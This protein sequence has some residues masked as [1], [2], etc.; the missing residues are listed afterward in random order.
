MSVKQQTVYLISL[1]CAKN[2]VDSEH[3]L[4]T[5]ATEGY[6]FTTDPK[7]AHIII[8]NTCAFITAAQEETIDTILEL[9]ELKKSGKCQH[10]VVTGCLAQRYAQDIA[11]QMPEVD[12]VLGTGRLG[13]LPE[14]LR[15]LNSGNTIVCLG[16]P[17]GLLEGQRLLSTPPGMAYLK[18]AEG[19]HHHC[20]YCIIPQLRGPL[21]SRPENSIVEE[22]RA[23][24]DQGVRELVLIA[25]D[26]A[27]YGLDLYG[28]RRLPHLLRKL[29]AIDNLQ[30]IRL[31]YLYPEHIN[32][33]LLAVM[34]EETKICHYLDMP[35]Q[36]ISDRILRAMGRSS[37]QETLL[38]LLT[39]VRRTLPDAALRTTF[40]VGFPGET[41][42][43]FLELLHFVQ[44]QKFDWVGAFAYSPQHGTPANNLPNQVP[45]KLK[46]ERLHEL[47]RCQ[48]PISR[49]RNRAWLGKKLPV[50]IE[51][52]S[53]Q[54]AI[55]RCFRQAP[56]VDGITY[57]RGEGLLPGQ[58]QQVVIE[59]TTTYDLKGRIVSEPT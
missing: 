20:T 18:L 59:Q 46:K 38:K 45:D 12:A 2:L 34:T 8:V 27:S 6:E 23:L 17:G 16:A 9:A 41:E 44:E 15:Q 19:C 48:R 57:V 1:G 54:G 14:V 13:D 31:L 39:Q 52:S 37:R 43:D 7:E 5:L 10:L 40:I 33:D 36:H 3:M 58:F 25:Q 21:V 56:D 53:S 55:G 30:W 51:Q 4:A 24:A 47:L 26:S 35:L 29:T 42:V 49:E 28:K 11:T 32:A 22:A 50:L